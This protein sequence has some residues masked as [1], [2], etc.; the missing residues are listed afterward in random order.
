MKKWKRIN[1]HLTEWK[2]FKFWVGRANIV[3]NHVNLRM[4]MKYLEFQCRILSAVT[5][6]SCI[7]YEETGL[8]N[9]QKISRSHTAKRQLL[10]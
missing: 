9:S 3:T 2:N 1:R 6:G 5:M 8:M 10:G 4:L 7:S